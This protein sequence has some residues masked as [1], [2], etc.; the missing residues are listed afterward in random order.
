MIALAV[1]L[2]PLALLIGGHIV[3]A[4]LCLLLQVTVIGWIPA[5]VWA[6]MVVNKDQ[7]DRR[8]RELVDRTRR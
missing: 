4:L 6:V 7:Q 8:Y 1:V 2:P 3:Q 5:A